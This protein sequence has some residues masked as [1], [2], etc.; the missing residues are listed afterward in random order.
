MDS[1]LTKWLKAT[2]DEL[3][4][5]SHSLGIAMN[6]ATPKQEH[7]LGEYYVQLEALRIKLDTFRLLLPA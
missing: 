4:T 6:G 5:A 3:F 1:H 7:E 2:T